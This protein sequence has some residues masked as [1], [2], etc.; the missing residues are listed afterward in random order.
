MSEASPK[1][2]KMT[3]AYTAATASE[4]MVVRG[5][6]ESAGLYTPNFGA[7]EPF[8]LNEPSELTHSTAVYVA[9]MQLD[10]ARKIIEDY[11]KSNSG[12][13]SASRTAE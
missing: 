6:L 1:P 12:N 4:A 7:A 3:R 2:V 11:L 9:E 8:P 10:E 13:E 5:L